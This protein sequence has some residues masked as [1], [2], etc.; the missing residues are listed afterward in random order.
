MRADQQLLERVEM[1]LE[2]A[3]QA[4]KLAHASFDYGGC[5]SFRRSCRASIQVQEGSKKGSG[6]RSC[7]DEEGDRVASPSNV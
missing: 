3:R 4:K 5:G 2:D 6:R 7:M 1:T